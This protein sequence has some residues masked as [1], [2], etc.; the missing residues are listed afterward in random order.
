MQ[1]YLLSAPSLQEVQD[2]PNHQE[3]LED[4]EK[5][6]IKTT[7]LCTVSHTKLYCCDFLNK[8]LTLTSAPLGP[9]GPR[10]PGGPGGP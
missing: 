6:H 5:T 10:G 4:P 3:D 1:K 7:V 9:A 2:Y 8:S